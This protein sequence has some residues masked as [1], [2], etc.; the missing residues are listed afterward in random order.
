MELTWNQSMMCRSVVRLHVTFETEYE[1]RPSRTTS[2]RNEEP[3]FCGM[4]LDRLCWYN[5][6]HSYCS[7]ARGSCS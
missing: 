3:I 7:T 2:S 4:R 5:S 6:S 1:L